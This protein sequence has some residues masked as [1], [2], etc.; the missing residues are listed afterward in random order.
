MIK[1]SEV[2]LPLHFRRYL[3]AHQAQWTR[4]WAYDAHL[5]LCHFHL[6]LEREGIQ[7]TKLTKKEV[8]RFIEQKTASCPSKRVNDIIVLRGFL[9]W[10]KETGRARVDVQTL[11]PEYFER[12]DRS[13]PRLA[14][15]YVDECTPRWKHP[16]SRRRAIYAINRLYLWLN[17]NGLVLSGLTRAHLE[18]FLGDVVN[19]QHYKATSLHGLQVHVRLYLDWLTERGKLEELDLSKIFPGAKNRTFRTLS[20]AAR[21]FLAILPAT[22]QIKTCVGYKAALCD[23]Y[24]FLHARKLSE[25]RINRRLIEAWILSLKK[26]GLAPASRRYLIFQLRIYFYWMR[27]R[28]KLRHDPE[29]LIRLTDIP[30]LPKL[31]PRPLPPDVDQEIQR[32]LEGSENIFHQGLLLLRRT[33]IRIGE[34]CSMPFDCVR[35]DHSG[36]W[37][38]K[39]PLGKL[40]NERL[41]PIDAATL[42]LIRK[43]QAHSRSRAGADGTEF[44][45]HLCYRTV[46]SGTYYSWFRNALRDVSHDLKTAEPIVAHR[47]RHTFATSL[48]N[49]GMSLYGVMRLLGHRNVTTTLIYASVA[50]DTIRSEYFS[51]LDRVREPCR[52]PQLEGPANLSD[53]PTEHLA[54]TI[55]CIQKVGAPAMDRSRALILKRLLRLKSEIEDLART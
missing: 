28:G 30:R 48:L 55:R 41:V 8:D 43:M 44:S 13:I 23:F 36:H 3:T 54:D 4:Y 7:L 50:Q 29:S 27:D 42:A 10:L 47:L 31:L 38:L 2:N 11:F 39:V 46:P 24:A 6:W 25:N 49:G 32:R 5:F 14:Q 16:S 52:I 21:A 20:P 35:E 22:K 15:K 1:I 51:A 17:K 33:G 26:K 53:D 18:R 19:S 45:N 12:W 40:H 34:L 9:F 37:Y